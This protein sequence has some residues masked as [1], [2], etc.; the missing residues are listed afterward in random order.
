MW[1]PL[2]I[3]WNVEGESDLPWISEVTEL[4]G[5]DRPG[6]EACT[7]LLASDCALPCVADSPAPLLSGLASGTSGS[8]EEASEK[9]P[10]ATC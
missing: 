6:L 7:V 8:R 5:A 3:A 2:L 4:A 10:K 1:R 9:A